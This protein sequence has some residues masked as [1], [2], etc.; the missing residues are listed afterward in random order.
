M[1]I[2]EIYSPH[3][4]FAK[5]LYHDFLKNFRENNFFSEESE[6]YLEIQTLLQMA[7]WFIYIIRMLSRF[8]ISQFD[9]TENTSC[10]Y[11]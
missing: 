5:F 4:E 7:E 11:L 3:V 8:G 1:E 6:K 10:P 2:T 9:L